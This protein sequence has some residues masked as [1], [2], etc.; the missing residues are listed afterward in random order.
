[1]PDN[2]YL[3]RAKYLDQIN[4]T[5]HPNS[6][7]TSLPLNN[8]VIRRLYQLL[9]VHQDNFSDT[10]NWMDPR[11]YFNDYDVHLPIANA[12]IN[13]KSYDVF[14]P[15]YFDTYFLPLLK[16]KPFILTVYDM[17]PEMFPQ[18]SPP[19]DIIARNKK[20]LV[21]RAAHIIAISQNTKNDLVKILNVDPAKI[22][23][24]HLAS[25]LNTKKNK[26]LTKKNNFGEYLL[27]VG[28]RVNYKN[29]DEYVTAI[30]PIL[31]Q[32]P[33]LKIVCVGD[34]PAS[35]PFTDQEISLFKKLRIRQQLVF[36]HATDEELVGL[37]S[38]AKAFIFPSL[39]EGFGIPVLEAFSCFCPV[40]CSNTSSLPEVAGNAAVY[41]D[42]YSKASMRDSLQ[43]FLKGGVR[44][45]NE[46]IFKGQKQLK[47]FTWDNS[48]KKTM[49]VYKLVATKHAS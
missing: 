10:S 4:P 21:H 33:K 17:I 29:F 12:L 9:N 23:V 43:N 27:Y 8:P 44:L 1:M 22:S 26:Q 34:K 45:R 19:G 5:V 41:F 15:T 3:K 42:P 25:S 32:N 2:I 14:H 46:L 38:Q 48:A 39:Y 30:A 40:M 16:A 49:A 18:Y 35:G 24:V 37:Y 13:S 20:L 47:S 7:P 6:T 36:T 11:N 31:H 28:T